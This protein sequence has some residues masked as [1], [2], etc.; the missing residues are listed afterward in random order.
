V[1]E[2]EATTLAILE[3]IGVHKDESKTAIIKR[4]KVNPSKTVNLNVPFVFSTPKPSPIR[5]SFG[6]KN[7]F[8]YINVEDVLKKAKALKDSV[9]YKSVFFNKDLTVTQIVHL[10]QLIK[11]RNTEN[12]KLDAKNAEEKITATYRYGIRDDRVVKVFFNK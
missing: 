6:A 1:K 5:V 10:K 2:D 7:G 12:S 3:E 11:T 4:F 8:T 9:K